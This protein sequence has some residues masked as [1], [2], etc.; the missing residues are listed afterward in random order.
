MPRPETPAL[1]VD[2]IIE[3]QDR[4]N[5]PIVLIERKYPPHGW[6]LPGGFVDVGET[7][8]QAARREAL[9][10][11]C[12]NVKLD[13]LLGCYSEPTRD[14][15][16]HTVSLVYIAHAKGEPKAED[17]AAGLALIDACELLSY[18]ER[19]LVFDHEKILVDYCRYRNVGGL[20]PL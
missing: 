1:T 13:T 15:R 17:D 16:G 2:I 9:E 14:P 4:L 18:R 12:L 5:H 11:T 10:E 20:P 19:E 6:A 8:E 3:M 7:V